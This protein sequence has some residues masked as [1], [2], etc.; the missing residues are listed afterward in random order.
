MD[1]FFLKF[2]FINFAHF[3][4]MVSAFFL[5]IFRNYI[6]WLQVL[7]P[8]SVLQISFLVLYCT[9]FLSSWCLNFDIIQFTNFLKNLPTLTKIFFFFQDIWILFFTFILIF[10]NCEVIFKMHYDPLFLTELEWPSFLLFPFFCPPTEISK[11]SSR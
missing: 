9:F 5:L 10:M 6:I 4:I 2:M 11:G 1:I 7:C 8:P 3:S